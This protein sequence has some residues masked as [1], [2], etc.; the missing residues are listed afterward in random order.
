VSSFTFALTKASHELPEALSE[1]CYSVSHVAICAH[2]RSSTRPRNK[3]MLWLTLIR[4]DLARV[5]R[6]F[7][8][9]VN[10]KGPTMSLRVGVSTHNDGVYLA[11]YRS[12]RSSSLSP[13]SGECLSSPTRSSTASLPSSAPL[14]VASCSSGTRHLLGK[15][16]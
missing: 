7:T 5:L 13:R 3:L 1:V 6:S 10:I 15:E 9:L 14:T 12:S 16:T 4:N 11:W 8:P 2:T